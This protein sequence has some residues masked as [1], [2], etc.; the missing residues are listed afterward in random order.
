[1]DKSSVPRSYEDFQPFTE[2]ISD[3]ISETLRIRLPGFSKEQLKVQMDNFGNLRAIGERPLD[4]SGRRWI[5][6]QTE[7]P[8]PE[9]C[10]VKGVRARFDNN[11]LYINFLKLITEESKPTIPPSTSLPKPELEPTPEPEKQPAVLEEKQEPESKR[12]EEEEVKEKVEEEKEQRDVDNGEK[13]EK[14][15]VRF[16]E[17]IK[18]RRKVVLNMFLALVVLVAIGIYVGYKMR[19]GAWRSKGE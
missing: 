6:F 16:L 14:M 9:G 7:H 10:D 3:D 1:M 15:R 18:R 8:I 5:R 12:K 13:E 4:V 19:R 17:R 11:I 2:W